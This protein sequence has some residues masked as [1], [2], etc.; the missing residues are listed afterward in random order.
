MKHYLISG[1]AACLLGAASLGVSPVALA[2]QTTE[3]D[4]TDTLADPRNLPEALTAEKA[5]KDAQSKAEKDAETLRRIE[6]SL[7]SIKSMTAAFVQRAPDGT[8]AEGTLSLERPGKLRFDF[9]DDA[10]FLV[11]S[12][13][14]LLTFIDYDVK[15]VSRWPIKKTP[16][17]IL[18]DDEIRFD[19]SVEVPDIVYFAG[20]VKVPVID[21]ERQEY[22]YIVLIFEESSMELRSWEVIDAQ[23]YTTRVALINPQYNVKIDEK[24][25]TYKDPRPP[26][27]GPRRH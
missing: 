11:V 17:G 10:P 13:G 6:K 16:L 5:P 7:N 2:Q 22:G 1:V 23:G 26:K 20:L 8:V 19:G 12:N 24:A 15:Q 9:G 4:L 27:R 18:V 14:N 21:P 25:F 3:P